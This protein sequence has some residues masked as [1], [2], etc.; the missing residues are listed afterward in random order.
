M[1]VTGYSS[2]EKLK[3]SDV[4][5]ASVIE[6][7]MIVFSR[8]EDG[9]LNGRILDG[10]T[11]EPLAGANVILADTNVGTS[12]NSNGEFILDLGSNKSYKVIVS[13]VGYQQASLSVSR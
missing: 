12:T 10:D 5:E 11:K 2:N 6:K 4:S 8:T 9:K 3:I 13:Y 1:Q 7:Q